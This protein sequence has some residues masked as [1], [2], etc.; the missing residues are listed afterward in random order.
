MK[1]SFII[2]FFILAALVCAAYDFSYRMGVSD[3]QNTKIQDTEIHTEEAAA[4]VNSGNPSVVYH[5]YLKEEDGYVSVY[6]NDKKTLY[7]YT[8]IRLDNIPEPLQK[9]IRNGKFL[10]GDQELYDFLENYSS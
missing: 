9:E 3:I 10:K 5:Y 2:S 6:L 4:A 7:E 8:T 1:R